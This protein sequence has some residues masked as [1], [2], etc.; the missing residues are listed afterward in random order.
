MVKYNLVFFFSE[1]EPNDKGLNLSHNKDKLLEIVGE[2]FD[3]IS[4]YTPKKL[5]DMG[6]DYYVKE[7]ETGH[8]RMNP[9]M[10][11][12]GNCAWRPL[13]M[14][15]E[16]EKMDEGDILVY[17]DSNVCGHRANQLSYYKDIR[18]IIDKCLETSNFDFFV[19]FEGK[20]NVFKHAK[21]NVIRELGEDHPFSYNFPNVFSGLLTIARKSHISNHFLNDWKEACEKEEWI[22][23]KTYGDLDPRFKWQCPE[24]SI[25][26]IIIS[27]WI[28][29]QQ[30]NISPYYPNIMFGGK[31]IKNII[32]L[33][34]KSNKYEHLKY[35]DFKNDFKN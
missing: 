34:E 15:L 13:I 20:G 14:L 8:V 19:P 17:R 35:L 7:R 10:S 2:H 4:W 33:D 21:T 31:I 9:G 12:I 3:N 32:V 27:N 18:N 24:Q 22:D 5:R 1:G 6:Y 23:G 28:R 25:L 16:L 30:Y 11:K 26:G 29:K